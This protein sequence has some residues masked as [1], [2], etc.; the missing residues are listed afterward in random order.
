MLAGKEYILD[1]V[2]D[3]HCG[4]AALE[5]H[6]I[7]SCD[8]R[9]PQ[10]KDARGLDLVVERAHLGIVVVSSCSNQAPKRNLCL[11]HGGTFIS[12]FDSRVYSA[13]DLHVRASAPEWA[14]TPDV[15]QLASLAT[16]RTAVTASAFRLDFEHRYHRCVVA[17]EKI[18]KSY[19][20]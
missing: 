15:A 12:F 10:S 20:T 11:P 8:H 9:I 5:Y 14:R 18:G 17:D 6:Y 1:I 2:R 19:R 3:A 7:D 13:G 16:E 4:G